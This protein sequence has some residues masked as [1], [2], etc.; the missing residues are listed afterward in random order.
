MSYSITDFK[1]EGLRGSYLTTQNAL[2]VIHDS[3]ADFQGNDLEEFGQALNK[4]AR[5]LIKT[6]SNL[7][8]LRKNATAVVYYLKRQVKAGKSLPEVK[9]YSLAKLNE[10][11]NQAATK[12]AA[13]G[14]YGAK[15]ILNQSK[16]MTLSYSSQLREIILKAHQLRRK[17]TVFIMESRPSLEGYTFAEEL[18]NLGIK[19][20]IITDAAIGQ[21]LPEMNMVITG[22]DRIHEKALISKTGTLTLA[23]LAGLFKIPYYVAAETDKILREYEHAVRFY[24]QP[25]REVYVPK[26]KTIDVTNYYFDSVS[27]EYVSKIVCE[28]G[29]F[30]IHEFKKWYLEE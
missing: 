1:K 17:F 21:F 15:L 20:H 24:S 23:V 12:K 25:S 29:I 9:K 16:L 13:I 30:D 5:D 7:V 6:Y 19:T 4:L 10:I 8:T 18:A 27:L 22:A 28:D 3:I 26:N 14:G 11:L 2:K